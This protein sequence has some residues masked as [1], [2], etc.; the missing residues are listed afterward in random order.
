MNITYQSNFKEFT[1]NA[2][3]NK[4]F[5]CHIPILEHYESQ[6]SYMLNSHQ[7]VMQVRFDLHYPEDGSVIPDQKHIYRFNENLKRSLDRENI[8]GRHRVDPKI[9][10][11]EEQIYS[12]YPHYHYVL[13]VNASAKRDI[14]FLFQKVEHFWELSIG[15][16][17]HGLVDY[18]NKTWN[19][20]KQENGI[21]ID[22]SKPDY[23]SNINKCFYQASYLAKECGKEHKRKGSWLVGSTRV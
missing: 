4:K 16:S 20:L 17:S 19:G 13:L 21:I 1:I 18:C 11:V 23:L 15:H 22:Q 12:N 6:L 9:I 3:I 2:D 10:H 14:Y 7:K 8:K 5:G